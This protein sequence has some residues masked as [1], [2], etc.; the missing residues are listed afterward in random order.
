M[1]FKKTDIK[2]LREQAIR[3]AVLAKPIITPT[4]WVF[5]FLFIVAANIGLYGT[6]HTTSGYDFQI[7]W[8]IVFFSIV[9]FTFIGSYIRESIARWLFADLD[10]KLEGRL[11]GI[12]VNGY[13]MDG[14]AAKKTAK[15]DLTAYTLESILDFIEK[16]EKKL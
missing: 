6:T 4:L 9:F 13:G 8:N 14:F 10:R 5:S 11:V 2:K 3:A 1:F 16:E 15:R 12:Y 7:F